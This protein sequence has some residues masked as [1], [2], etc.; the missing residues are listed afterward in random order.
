[1]AN[2]TFN[3]PIGFAG[4]LIRCTISDEIEISAVNEVELLINSISYYHL[5]SVFNEERN[6]IFELEELIKD[7]FSFD[8]SS[9]NVLSNKTVV[10]NGAILKLKLRYFIAGSEY[11]GEIYCLDACKDEAEFGGF[12]FQNFLVE[13]NYLNNLPEVNEICLDT[14]QFV[15]ILIDEINYLIYQNITVYYTDGTSDQIS[16]GSSAKGLHS[17]VQF[18]CGYTQL[19]LESLNTQNKTVYSYTFNFTGYAGGV[20]V[21]WKTLTFM[22]KDNPLNSIVF[23]FKNAFGVPQMFMASGNLEEKKLSIKKEINEKPRDVSVNKLSGRYLGKIR[24]KKHTYTASTGYLSR[25]EMVCFEEMLLSE[26]VYVL[27]SDNSFT[28]IEIGEAEYK[29]FDKDEEYNAVVFE[30]VK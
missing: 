28:K 13:G 11:F 6:L 1:M 14:P 20:T 15:S 9:L 23:C 10:L 27:E 22:I 2:F 17:V 8:I 7:K 18:P 4:N 24:E 3:K 26:N 29:L 5:K 16:Y 21:E 30:Y 25:A 12:N 19:N